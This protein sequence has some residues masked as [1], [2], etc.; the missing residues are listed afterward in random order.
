MGNNLK[1]NLKGTEYPGDYI[2][3]PIILETIDFTGTQLYKDIQKIGPQGP[4]GPQGP[5]GR[6]G[7]DG[8]MGPQ[9]QKGP[10]GP[11]G[12]IG[13]PG[14]PGPPGQNNP[15][16]GLPGLVGLTGPMGPMGLYSIEQGSTM[17][18]SKTG[19]YAPKTP[20][21]VPGSG[22]YVQRSMIYDQQ[23]AL[24]APATGSL[25][26]AP[27]TGSSIYVSK[28][29]L[30]NNYALKNQSAYAPATGST[31]YAP[32]TG[33][34]VYQTIGAYAPATGSNV[35]APATGSNVYA[36]A[37]GSPNYAPATGSP[38]YAPATGSPV[39]YSK[40]GSRWSP[41]VSLGS[42]NF[43]I[44][45]VSYTHEIDT[46]TGSVYISLVGNGG[47]LTNV[48]TMNA[49]TNGF[50]VVSLGGDK[51]TRSTGHMVVTARLNEGESSIISGTS[52]SDNEFPSG[53]AASFSIPVPKNKRIQ[54][55]SQC[56]GNCTAP[57]NLVANWYPV[58]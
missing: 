58:I 30:I 1:T 27:S 34:T 52:Y 8:P 37:T 10:D 11:T 5:T 49:D 44:N 23:G 15:S 54:V 12:P 35:Y 45:T 40:S 7:P 16:V 56:F 18:A 33:S 32:K 20:G 3:K 50:L 9:G 46:E 21:P 24:F 41:N 51:R 47:L 28:S 29:H 6:D 55:F 39:Y 14:P 57:V 43:T 26:Y 2:I 42:S 13:P 53:T 17:Y 48:F 36:P 25:E 38:N 22:G 4:E 19:D 31:E